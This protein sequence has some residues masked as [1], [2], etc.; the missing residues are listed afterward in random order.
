MV[1]WKRGRWICG[2]NAVGAK[3]DGILE[4]CVLERS[5][6]LG[7]SSLLLVEFGSQ[8]PLFPFMVE[9]PR[10]TREAMMFHGAMP[11]EMCP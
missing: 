8:Q 1:S 7:I 5:H 9:T 6:L 2:S 4:A 10:T 3:H 11:I